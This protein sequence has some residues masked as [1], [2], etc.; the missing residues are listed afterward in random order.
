MMCSG[1]WPNL[2]SASATI[3][4]Y[5]DLTSEIVALA[6]ERLREDRAAQTTLTEILSATRYRTYCAGKLYRTKCPKRYCYSRD[7]FLYMID[8]YHLAKCVKR[9]A[10]ALPFLFHMARATKRKPG[11]PPFPHLE[12]RSSATRQQDAVPPL[13]SPQSPARSDAY[14][15]RSD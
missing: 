11:R 8:C 13:L 6:V 15:N 14:V 12:P 4:V 9:G 2:V 3:L 7:S 10:E 5:L 1:L